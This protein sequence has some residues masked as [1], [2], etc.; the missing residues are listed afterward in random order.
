MYVKLFNQIFDSSIAEDCD[1]RHIFMDLLI[2]ADQE[3]RVDMTTEAIARRINVPLERLQS[4]INTLSAPDP[5]S[6]S[7]DYE[8]RR[9]I[10]LDPERPWGWLCVN[11]CSY[12]GLRDE[13]ARREYQKEWVKKKRASA[14]SVDQSLTESTGVDRGLVESPH[15]NESSSSDESSSSEVPIVPPTSLRRGVEPQQPPT[16][17]KLLGMLLKQFNNKEQRVILDY[18]VEAL[19]PKQKQPFIDKGTL[20]DSTRMQDIIL[21]LIELADGKQL[22]YKYQPVP[23]CDHE[24]L[25]KSMAS[26]ARTTKCRFENN[27]FLKA[28]LQRGIM[29]KLPHVYGDA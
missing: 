16:A 2:L 5:M 27:N 24:T 4:A 14:K 28:G 6:R 11:Y 29:D 15:T 12:K 3:G 8:G 1:A 18:L 17:R 19:S 26:A 7:K 10:P 20:A 25:I 9:L 21:E 13:D 22:T 23:I